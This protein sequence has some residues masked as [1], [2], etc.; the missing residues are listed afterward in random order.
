MKNKVFAHRGIPTLAPENTAA[1]FEEVSKNDIE[2]LETDLS[3][4][5]DKKIFIIHDDKLD[6]TTDLTGS[7]ETVMSSEVKQADAGYW[8]DNKFRG[9]KIMTLDQLIQFLNNTKINANIELKGVVGPDANELANSLVTQFASAL[10]DLDEGI[11]LIISSFNP[12]MLQKMY[13]LCPDLKYA[14]L[15]DKDSLTE[16]WNLTMQVCHAKIIHP[17]T[18]NLTRKKVKMFK[19]YGYQV[20]VWTVDDINRAQQLF[21][22]GVD[23]IFTNIA[24][25]MK[26]FQK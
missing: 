23:G 2:W 21:N 25:R 17:D 8:F 13:R 15:F 4:T 20:N 6:R 22:W 5:K 19:D 7:I 18:R 9:E 12:I 3:I 14:V 11:E 24:D 1:S 10:D 26:K 16:D